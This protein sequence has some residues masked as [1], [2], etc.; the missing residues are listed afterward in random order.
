MTTRERRPLAARADR[1]G[2][3]IETF[4]LVSVLGAMILIAAAQIA[5]RN[6]WNTGFDWADEA[7]RIMVLWV[8]ILGA[9]A[10]SREGRHV[11][12]DAISRYLPP[13]VS[14]W[15]RVLVDA[16]AALVCAV[17]AWYSY[18]FVAGSH[19][20]GDRILGGEFPAWCVQVIL[21]V[22]FALIAYRY[23][24]ACLREWSSGPAEVVPL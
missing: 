23:L 20:A 17:L 15:T 12:I 19:A 6:F 16:F 1:L 3:I 24:V 8:T 18:Q 4:L 21:P 14:R 9:V 7:L 13:A 10:A 5:L 22:G 11:S 2:R